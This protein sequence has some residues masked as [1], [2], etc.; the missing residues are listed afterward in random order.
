[1]KLRIQSKV[2]STYVYIYIYIYIRIYTIP[3]AT[4]VYYSTE[5][6]Y[7]CNTYTLL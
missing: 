7:S 2:N 4:N 1:M 5:Y 6:T 3:I